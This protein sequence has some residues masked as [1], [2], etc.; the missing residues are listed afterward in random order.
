MTSFC[1]FFATLQF[2]LW[3][4]LCEKTCS[5]FFLLKIACYYLDGKEDRSVGECAGTLC[6]DQSY[7]RQQKNRLL[8]R[9]KNL[10]S[11][12]KSSQSLHL[13]FLSSKLPLFLIGLCLEKKLCLKLHMLLRLNDL[14]IV[15]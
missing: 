9:S 15:Q 4:V 11:L 1:F 8:C 2:C 3:Y 10:R 5:W 13:L 6:P 12:H 7:N 14:S